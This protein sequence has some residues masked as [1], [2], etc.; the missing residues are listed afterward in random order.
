MAGAKYVG[1]DNCPY[2]WFSIALDENG[3]ETRVCR[4]FGQLL[5]Y[6][7]DATLILVDVPIGL[8]EN[9]AGRRCDDEARNRIGPQLTSAVFPTPTR[10]TIEQVGILPDCCLSATHVQFRF[11][12]YQSAYGVANGINLQTF[13]ISHKIAEVDE[14]M[15]GRADDQRPAIREVHRK[16]ASGR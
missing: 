4:T 13:G 15:R 14:V 7:R 10:Q 5:H 8:P 11:R 3:Y 6:Y 2:G 12:E 1:V 16:F 9:Q